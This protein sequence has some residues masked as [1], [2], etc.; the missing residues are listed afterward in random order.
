MLIIDR[1]SKIY[2]LPFLLSSFFLF[3]FLFKY[4]TGENSLL[5][6]CSLSIRSVDFSRIY[7]KF[8]GRKCMKYVITIFTR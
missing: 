1:V 8:G 6:N 7:E 3:F 5:V 2:V 4:A